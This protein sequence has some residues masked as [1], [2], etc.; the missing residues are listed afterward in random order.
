[1]KFIKLLMA[2]TSLFGFK[3]QPIKYEMVPGNAL[4]KFNSIEKPASLAPAD[5]SG[6]PG[7]D[8]LF[9]Q[10]PPG[11][12]A[13][14]SAEFKPSH[15][16]SPSENR[17]VL[18]V[19]ASSDRAED[20]S[21]ETSKASKGKFRFSA[22][23]AAENVAKASRRLVQGELGLDSVRVV[24]N[25]LNDSDMELVAVEKRK[26]AA[27]RESPESRASKAGEPVKARQ[28]QARCAVEPVQP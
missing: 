7:A 16:T 27:A 2:G 3:R 10:K 20:F 24:R 4:P 9:E 11:G 12:S 19:G 14:Q 18:T 6:A 26:P 28:D 17:G 23:F 1:M 8:S 13:S 15:K 5:E 25:D 22:L 21:C